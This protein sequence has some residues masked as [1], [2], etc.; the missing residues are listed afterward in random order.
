M[1]TLREMINLIESAQ[2]PMLESNEGIMDAVKIEYL[3]TMIDAP[4]GTPIE[5]FVTQWQNGIVE[6]TGKTVP[7]EQLMKL[8]R[9]FAPRNQEI[10]RDIETKYGSEILDETSE[11]PI[12]RI[13]KLFQDKR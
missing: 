13:E 8:K 9:D 3:L 4:F 7:T 12:R 10:M 1:K 11:D 2:Q 5:E 6:R